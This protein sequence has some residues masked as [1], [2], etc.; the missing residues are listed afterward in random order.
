MWRTRRRRACCSLELP[1]ELVARILSFLNVRSLAACDLVSLAFHRAPP[2][3]RQ[4][5]VE[6]AL[7]LRAAEA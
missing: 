7:R 3:Q 5:L 2:P 1:P 6:Q 4:G